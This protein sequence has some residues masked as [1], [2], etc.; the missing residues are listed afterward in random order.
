MDIERDENIGDAKQ[1]L[2]N[3]LDK[4]EDADQFTEEIIDAAALQQ[5]MERGELERNA[6]QLAGWQV[7]VVDGLSLQEIISAM[8]AIEKELKDI[9][10]L[11]RE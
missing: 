3:C 4:L 7:E 6:G 1:R 10:K 2:R 8:V 9:E 11:M 5:A